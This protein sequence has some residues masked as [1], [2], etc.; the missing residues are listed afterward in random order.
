MRWGRWRTSCVARP[1]ARAGTWSAAARASASSG[2]PPRRATCGS[3]GPGRW[4]TGPG[5]GAGG[6]ILVALKSYKFLLKNKAVY[7][8]K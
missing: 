1:A 4:R 3:T 5:R 2:E 6:G 8:R 7:C